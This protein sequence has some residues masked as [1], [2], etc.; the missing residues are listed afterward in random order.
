MKAGLVLAGAIIGI[1]VGGTLVSFL[2]YDT[3]DV[4]SGATVIFGALP[5]ALLGGWLAWKLLDRK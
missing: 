3:A 2:V 5:G 1:F 4:S